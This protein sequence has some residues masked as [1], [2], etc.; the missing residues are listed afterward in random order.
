MLNKAKSFQGRDPVRAADKKPIPSKPLVRS[1]AEAEREIAGL[2]RGQE[3]RDAAP[4]EAETS[5]RA[6]LI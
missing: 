2:R 3:A 5:I 4:T 1:T 6:S